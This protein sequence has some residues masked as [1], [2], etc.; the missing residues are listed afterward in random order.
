CNSIGIRTTHSDS[1]RSEG[2]S[3]V[4]LI[5]FWVRLKGFIQEL[6]LHV[7]D[8][9]IEPTNQLPTCL[10]KVNAVYVSKVITFNIKRVCLISM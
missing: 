7:P 3:V 2:L 5:A 1:H 10:M 6:L 8:A 4:S 9:A